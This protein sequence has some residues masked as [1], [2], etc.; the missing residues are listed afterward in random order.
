ML[1][2]LSSSVSCAIRPRTSRR[3]CARNDRRGDARHRPLGGSDQ[4]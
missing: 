2:L 4:P 1:D 3:T